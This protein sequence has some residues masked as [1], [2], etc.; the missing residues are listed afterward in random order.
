MSRLFFF[1]VLLC[2]HAS[3][4]ST[5]H[6]AREA[7]SQQEYAVAARLFAKAGKEGNAEGYFKAGALFYEGKPGLK[8]NFSKTYR[9]FTRASQMGHVKAKY[10]LGIFYSSRRTP[11]FDLKQAY[12]IFHQLASQG[13]PGAQNRVGM[14]L[15]Y[16]MSKITGKDYIEAVKWFEKSSMQGYE[17]ANC[18]LAFMYAS[19]KGVWQNLGRAHAF[20]KKGKR[21]GIKTCKKV[22]NDFKL[23]K[24]T[25]DKGWKFKFY[26]QPKDN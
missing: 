25:E 14:F 9:Y 21:K 6:K 24:Y 19:G 17:L 1:L 2:L 18:N 3:A 15:L 26:T 16:G 22:W 23:A 11:F 12:S 13:H 10:N 20:A 8:Q 7:L 5:F 4:V